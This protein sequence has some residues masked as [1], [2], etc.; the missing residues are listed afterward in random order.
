MKVFLIKIEFQHQYFIAATNS[1]PI[2]AFLFLFEVDSV[3]FRVTEKL[4]KNIHPED[5]IILSLLIHLSPSSATH[6]PK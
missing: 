2:A 4:Q 5:I 6:V 1:Y 3:A